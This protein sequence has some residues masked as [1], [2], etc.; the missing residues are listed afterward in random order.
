M[1]DPI[2]FIFQI[3]ILIMSV[4]IHELSHGYAA[5]FLGDPTARMAGRLTLNPI[6]H[7]DPMGSFFVPLISFFSFGFIFG[8]AKPVPYN[9]YNLKGPLAEAFVASAG[10]LANLALAL[11]FGLLIRFGATT[12]P[13]SFI[14]I[15]SLI[16]LINIILMIFNLMP[17]PPLDGSKV[18]FNLLPFN[19]RH[20][21]DNLERWGFVIL[22]FFIFF[23]W[24]FLAP[25]IDFLYTLIV[26]MPLNFPF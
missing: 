21:Q 26:G 25:L 23:L 9:P 1:Q 5:N 15:A 16:V 6:K 10:V 12:L 4:V 14:D 7:L 17:I 8:W 18:L 19:L 13:T 24:R 11:I 3:A 20:I 22:L 2:I